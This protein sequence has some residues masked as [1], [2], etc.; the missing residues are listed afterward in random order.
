ML[1]KKI[2]ALGRGT[3]RHAESNKRR[4]K[5]KN[6]RKDRFRFPKMWLQGLKT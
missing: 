6:L 3:K 2:R 1:H 4:R 5:R